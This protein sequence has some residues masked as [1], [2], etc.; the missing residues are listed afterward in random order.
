VLRAWHDGEA[1]CQFV[2]FELDRRS[3]H[4]RRRVTVPIRNGK[5]RRLRDRSPQLGVGRRIDIY[6]AL[7]QGLAPQPGRRY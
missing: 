5:P 4:G 2:Q 1:S 6:P 3:V 7:P